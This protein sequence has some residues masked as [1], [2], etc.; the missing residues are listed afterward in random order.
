M[1]I[2]QSTINKGETTRLGAGSKKHI[3]ELRLAELQHILFLS[4]RA[5]VFFI[6]V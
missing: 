1:I 5:L 6:I 2:N 3:K 4:D